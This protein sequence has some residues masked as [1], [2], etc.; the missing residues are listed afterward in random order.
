MKV[1]MIDGNAVKESKL[2]RGLN[3]IDVLVQEDGM[4]A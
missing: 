1:G 3:C 4:R 2:E